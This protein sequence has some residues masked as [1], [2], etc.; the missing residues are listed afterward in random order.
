MKGIILAGGY[1]TRLYP[2]TKSISKNILP[3][4]DKPTVYYT[5]AILMLADIRDILIISTTQDIS[6]YERLLGDGNKLGLN[7]VYKI[8][9]SPC[10]L[11]DAFIIGEDFIGNDN[12]AL[13][14]GDNIIYGETFPDILH[15]AANL[16]EGAIIFGYYVDNPKSY[17]VVE[18]DKNGKVISLEEKPSAPKSN[19][20]VPGIY[21]YDNK[22]IE[23]A[24]SVLPS[25]RGEIEITDIN[26]AYLELGQLQVKILNDILWIDTG[27]YDNLLDVSNFI[28]SIQREKSLYIGAIEQIAY[29]K[30]YINREQL[31]ALAE[32]MSKSGYGAYLKSIVERI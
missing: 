30:G 7:F 4:Y 15:E 31:L 18:F 8:Q 9:E 25:A 24:K 28:R 5:I 21:F 22:V 26:K 16:N 20:A 17:G 13:I 27:T 3:I 29:E 2:I 6:A 1:G 10:G 23:I 19:Y 11:A 12:V 32:S 14:L